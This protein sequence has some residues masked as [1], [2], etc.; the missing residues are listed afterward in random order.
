ME[1]MRERVQ[2]IAFVAADALH[3]GPAMMQTERTNGE[4]NY[5]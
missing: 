1:V 4:R 2:G 5:G 3:A